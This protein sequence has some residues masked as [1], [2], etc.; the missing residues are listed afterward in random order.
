[1]GCDFSD[2]CN[3]GAPI[4]EDDFHRYILDGCLFWSFGSPYGIIPSSLFTHNTLPAEC[5][6]ALTWI[7]NPDLPTIYAPMLQYLFAV[8][9]YLAP[10]NVDAL[11]LI[12]VLFDLALIYLLRNMAPAR[13]ILLYR[14][15][16]FGC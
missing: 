3:L 15:V 5:Q 10:A 13:N 8:S 12:V 6:A 7:N 9:Y 4:L 16:P 14:L 2:Y 11:Q 1:M